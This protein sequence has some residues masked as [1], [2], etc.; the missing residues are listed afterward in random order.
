MRIDS[1]MSID[2]DPSELNEVAKFFKNLVMQPFGMMKDAKVTITKQVNSD[3]LD[4][5]LKEVREKINKWY[6]YTKYDEVVNKLRKDKYLFEFIQKVVEYKELKQEVQSA[7]ETQKISIR[8]KD[9]IQTVIIK[10]L[11]LPEFTVINL[12]RPYEYSDDKSS[13]ILWG[14]LHTILIQFVKQI[15][16]EIGC[17]EMSSMIHSL[18]MDLLGD[19]SHK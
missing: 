2:I 6:S 19:A 15:K 4:E 9:I 10:L 17:I 12:G 3:S 13:N 11:D 5:K 7:V 14:Y 8:L 1:R 18:F 16:N